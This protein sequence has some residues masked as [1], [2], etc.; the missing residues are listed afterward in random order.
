MGRGP[1]R[2]NFIVAE[3]PLLENILELL[4]NQLRIKLSVFLLAVRVRQ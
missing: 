4:Q 1:F 3:N 2:T